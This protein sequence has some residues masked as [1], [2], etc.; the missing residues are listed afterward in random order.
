L[1]KTLQERRIAG[2]GLDVF[3]REPLA[4]D[5]PLRK[6]PNVVLMPHQGHNVREFYE[7]AYSDVVENIAA[8]VRG[9]PI[10]ILS[11]AANSSLHAG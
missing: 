10:R 9:S 1:I 6:L 4:D 8:F 3:T 11:A 5:S 7:V 2:A